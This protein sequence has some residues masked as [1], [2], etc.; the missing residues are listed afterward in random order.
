MFK[1]HLTRGSLV[2]GLAVGAA[3]LPAAAQA[4]V[5][6]PPLSGVAVSGPVVGGSSVQ[7]HLGQLQ[8]NV[9]KR[10]AAQGSW[11]STSS[12]S[13]TAT[14]HEDFQWG[15]AG[16]GAAGVLVLL[17]AAAAGAGVTRRRRVRRT[18]I[19]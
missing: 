6:P 14:S 11:P 10:F 16:I 15:D 4:R 1:H 17:G 8:S 9:R 19:G 7:Q 2:V 12:V 18:A 3:G 13:S 5:D